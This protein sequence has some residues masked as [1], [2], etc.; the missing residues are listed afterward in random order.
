MFRPAPLTAF[1]GSFS[2]AF[3]TPTTSELSNRP[4]EAG[5][6]NPGLEPEQLRGF[7]AGVKGFVPGA[8]MAYDA[9]VFA[10]G[11]SN[12][13]LPFQID[14]P[15]TDEI[16]FR[17][18]GK[19]RN[20]GIELKLAWSPVPA[21]DLALAYT[22]MRFEFDDFELEREVDGNTRTYQ[23]SGNEV[24]GV[25]PHHLFAGFTYTDP[26][27]GAFMEMN[28]QWTAEYF[29]NDFNG[30]APGSGKP[31]SDFVN[32]GYALVDLR[33]GITY[34][35]DMFGAVLFAGVNNLFDTRYNGSI[36]PNAFGDRF[37][38]PAAGR[39]WYVGFGLPVGVGP[40]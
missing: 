13:L 29:A 7:E 37:F 10:Y 34:N 15:E 28:A 1:Y 38:E 32:D 14:N 9:A 26:G 19:T 11:I 23:L 2:T 3:Q 8:G 18:A 35:G 25:P 31:E 12:M 30:P 5:G 6:F 24:P 4:T 39:T 16:Y 36:V 40:R 27:S 17:N 21:L 33:A 20:R 22:G